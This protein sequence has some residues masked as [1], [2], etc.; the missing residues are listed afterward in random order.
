MASQ[1]HVLAF[2][3]PL[4]AVQ[5][6]FGALREHTAGELIAARV[7]GYEAGQDAAHDF[8]NQQIVELRAEMQQLQEG[9]LTRIGQAQDELTA[10]VRRALPELAVEIG[11]RLLAGFVPPPELVEKLC[12]E[13]LD[14]LYPE[15]DGLELVVGPR[16]AA[17]LERLVPSWRAHFTNLRITI[18]DTL[19]PGDCL[20]RSRFGVTDA[21]GESKIASLKQELLGT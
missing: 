11:Q 2:D 6:A 21:R 20:V 8:S 16:D 14:Q 3:R 17:V 13:A 7:A 5:P 10:Q 1:H 4:I 19:N 18:D 15:R 9:I 12:R